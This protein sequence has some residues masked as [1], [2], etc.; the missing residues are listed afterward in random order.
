MAKADYVVK[1]VRLTWVLSNHSG[2]HVRKRKILPTARF[3][4]DNRT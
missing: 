4:V 2:W 3:E 1:I